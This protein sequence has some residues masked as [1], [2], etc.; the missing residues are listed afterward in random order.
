MTRTGSTRAR[1]KPRCIQ[2]GPGPAFFYLIPTFP[3]S[4]SGRA[5]E[6]QT[7]AAG[8]GATQEHDLLVTARRPL[9]SRPVRGRPAAGALRPLQ[10][11]GRLQ[12]VVLEDDRT[13]VTGTAGSC[14]PRRW[15]GEVEATR[16]ATY[17]TPGAAGP[18]D[19]VGLV[20]ARSLR[21]NLGRVIEPVEDLE[22]DAMFRSARPPAGR[23]EAPGG[24]R[25]DA[26]TFVWLSLDGAD[27]GRCARARRSRGALSVV[28]GPDFGGRPDTL[29]LAFSLVPAG[30]IREGV[31]RLAAAPPVWRESNAWPR[32]PRR[33]RQRSSGP[34]GLAGR[35]SARAAARNVGHG[36]S[37]AIA[38]SP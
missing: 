35:C 10:R 36:R 19:R 23:G 24:A 18:G 29:R 37:G 12:L 8:G 27:V 34:T 17:I 13:R 21:E 11:G 25:P 30:G 2:R 20:S 1:S 6:G 31:A 14:C 5:L 32:R 4:P 28:P 33:W 9:L 16:T 3:E 22:R 15:R 38:Q 7:P 26:D